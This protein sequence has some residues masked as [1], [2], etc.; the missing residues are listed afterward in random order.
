M[1]LAT[2]YTGYLLFYDILHSGSMSDGYEMINFPRYLAMN[3]TRR[4][5]HVGE[6][7]WVISNG[8]VAANLHDDFLKSVEPNL[9]ALISNNY[10]VLL[11]TGNF[12]IT[13]GV[14]TTSGMLEYKSMFYS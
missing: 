6:R 5:L 2:N 9:T 10:K 1:S 11:Y 14:A 4:A 13:V 12:D 3:Q 8:S 7:E